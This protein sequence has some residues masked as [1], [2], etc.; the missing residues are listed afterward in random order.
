MD[1]RDD[2]ETGRQCIPYRS[3]DN[4]KGLAADGR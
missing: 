1:S 4:W 3:G 2:A